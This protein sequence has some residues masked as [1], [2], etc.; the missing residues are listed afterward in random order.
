MSLESRTSLF[1]D[2][3]RLDIV[4]LMMIEGFGPATTRAHLE[5]IR[6]DGQSI[7]DGLPARDFAEA[8]RT[9]NRHLARAAVIG[10]RCVIP[11][12]DDYPPRLFLLEHPP[13]ALWV[14]CDLAVVREPKTVAIVGT[15]EFT[16]YG[17]RVS[18]SLAGAF[19]R[20]GVTVVS[21]MARGIDAA[22][23]IATLEAGGKTAAVL[24][25]GVDVPYPAAHRGLHARIRANGVVISEAPP[26]APAVIGCFPR[27]NR[28]IAALGDATLVVEAG[29]RSGALNTAEWAEGL[30]LKVGVTPGPID[31]P[32]SLGSN[33]LLRDGAHVVATIE[34]ALALIGI[35]E[36]GKASIA[37]ESP[38]EL[39]V[40]KALD[41]PAANFDVLCARTG[42][43]GRVCMETVTALELRGIV[44]CAMTGELRRR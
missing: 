3:D 16:A 44:D 36:P 32:A 8:R 33:L 27:R 17:Q 7:D 42:L 29:A 26:G 9:A 12:D 20:S 23:H 6:A 39:S 15:R 35:S 34:D 41:R 31:S 40:W 14:M 30:G 38:A 5:R 24:G 28:L 19:V 11:G 21:G 10:A 43:P 13:V 25:T 37:L 1:L 22:A 2:I 4:A 18:R